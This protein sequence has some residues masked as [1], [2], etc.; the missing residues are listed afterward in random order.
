MKEAEERGWP[1]IRHMMLVFPNSSGVY[2]EELN[3]QFMVGDA[4][5][6]VPVVTKGQ[7]QVRAFLPSGT[8]WRSIW[9]NDKT[10]I[11]TGM[12]CTCVCMYVCIMW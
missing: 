6:V 2:K 11:F 4:L 7:Q 9:E 12:L 10:V 3:K 8:R 1:V 5:L